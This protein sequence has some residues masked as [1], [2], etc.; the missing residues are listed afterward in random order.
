MARPRSTDVLTIAQ[1]RTLINERQTK[2]RGLRK[3]ERILKGKLAKVQHQIAALSGE[4][5]DGGGL[6]PRN[7]KNLVDVIADVMAGKKEPMGVGEIA[8]A[9][10]AAG[11]RSSSANFK[12]IVNQTLIKEKRFTS[13]ARGLYQLR[14]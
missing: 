1:L 2:L 4:N 12:G 3:E 11:Y 14:K 9:A 10:L 7:E 13:P 5:G 6:R 8:E